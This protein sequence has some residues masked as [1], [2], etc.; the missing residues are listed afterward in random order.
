MEDDIQDL[1]SEIMRLQAL[2]RALNERLNRA[3][4]KIAPLHRQRIEKEGLTVTFDG[5]GEKSPLGKSLGDIYRERY[6]NSVTTEYPLRPY[7]G[8]GSMPEE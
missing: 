7:G 6:D 5:P 3:E 4:E 2:V 1:K 8:P